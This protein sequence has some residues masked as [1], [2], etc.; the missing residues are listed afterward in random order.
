M[1]CL[2]GENQYNRTSMNSSRDLKEQQPEKRHPAMGCLYAFLII[3]GLIILAWGMGAGLI[4]SDRLKQVDA[5]VVLSGGK[6]DRL[7]EAVN[8]FNEGYAD[9]FIMTKAGTDELDPETKRDLVKIMSA[10]HLGIPEDSVIITDMTANSTVEEAQAVLHEMEYYGY[11]SIIVVTDSFH[12]LRSKIIFASVMRGKGVTVIM[13]AVSN[14]WFKRSN[15]FL[16]QEGWTAAT[17]EWI[18]LLGFWVGVRSD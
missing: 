13:H 7:T 14:S 1:E 17:S 10:V 15:W 18:K 16:S 4:V 2:L 12:T 11:K 3:I 8:L 5:I 9:R 6:A